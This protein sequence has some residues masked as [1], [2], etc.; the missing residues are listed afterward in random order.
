MRQ[1]TTQSLTRSKKTRHVNKSRLALKAVSGQRMPFSR[2]K[3]NEIKGKDLWRSTRSTD[4]QV[5][6]ERRAK[7]GQKVHHSRVHEK[8]KDTKARTII[9]T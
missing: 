8:A 9:D 2:H 3:V 1:S 4:P 6:T 7:Q 5:R